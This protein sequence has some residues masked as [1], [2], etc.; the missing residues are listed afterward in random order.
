MDNL[1]KYNCEGSILRQHQMRML[2]ML[3]VF[4]DICKKNNISYWLSFGTLLGAVRHKGFIPWD[5]DLDVEILQTDYK[6]LLKVLQNELPSNFAVQNSENEPF[7]IAPYFKI[8]DLTSVIEES[9]NRDNKYLYKGI[10]ID[11]FTIERSG[12]ITAKI[13]GRIFYRL[14]DILDCIH[15]LK[16]IKYLLF[17]FVLFIVKLSVIIIRFVSTFLKIQQYRVSFG[18]GLYH[19]RIYDNIFPL[20]E[21]E[22][23]GYMFKAPRDGHNFLTL[24]YGNYMEIPKAEDI[25][26]H[27]TNVKFL[28]K[29]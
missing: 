7:Y 15:N 22:F 18:S 21:V 26:A 24:I 19:K 10:Y 5:D 9:H 14:Y 27:V 23:E 25:K 17:C 29:L 28:N 3:I 12:L 16:T 20:T 6:K 2:E 11:I 13:Y 8:R 4:D 1:R